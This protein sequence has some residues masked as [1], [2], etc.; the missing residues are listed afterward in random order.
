[1]AATKHEAPADYEAMFREYFDFIK[2]YVARAGIESQ[3]VED[4]SMEIWLKFREKDFLAEYDPTKVFMTARGPKTASF[5]SLLASFV[6]KYVLSYRDKQKKRMENEPVRCETPVGSG[7]DGGPQMWL[8]VYGPHAPS[9]RAVDDVDL[10]ES[11]K[12]A[13]QALSALPIRGA[14]DRRR[15]LPRMFQMLVS[16]TLLDG[17][18]S[19]RVI[20]KAFGVSETSVYLMI[21]DLQAALRDVGFDLVLRS[22]A[23]A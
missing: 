5:K 20:A 4:V 23:V 21:R 6:S 19:R 17:Q 2:A 14:N 11:I 7:G 18:V 13:Y 22:D 12:S 3:E 15:H 10:M 16:Q 1:M 9:S 8:E